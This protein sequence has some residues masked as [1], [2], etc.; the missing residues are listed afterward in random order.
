MRQKR[1]GLG[2]KHRKQRVR[3]HHGLELELLVGSEPP[4]CPLVRQFVIAC[5]RLRVR[6]DAN[7][8]AGKIQAQASRQRSNQV[9]ECGAAAPV[10]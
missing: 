7:Q 6:P 10:W 3:T 8:G 5:L 9:L 1:S 4:F 2:F